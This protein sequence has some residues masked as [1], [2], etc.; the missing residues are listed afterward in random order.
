MTV[1]EGHHFTA[2]ASPAGEA[3]DPAHNEITK[4]SK[5]KSRVLPGDCS[6]R[7]N[8]GG[9]IQQGLGRSILI[10]IAPVGLTNLQQEQTR[11][12]KVKVEA[13][14]SGC[15]INQGIAAGFRQFPFVV[16]A[17]HLVGKQRFEFRTTITGG[18]G[19]DR[20]VGWVNHKI[21]EVPAGVVQSRDVCRALATTG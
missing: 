19:H 9:R 18:V 20:S 10:A 14:R 15:R 13:S 16:T 11:N 7:P 3:V 1:I 21:S 8:N 5:A 6:G 4:A 17:S 2:M 12:D